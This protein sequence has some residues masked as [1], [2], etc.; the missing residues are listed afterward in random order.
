MKLVIQSQ[1]SIEELTTLVNQIFTKIQN[2][3]NKNEKQ[4]KQDEEEEEI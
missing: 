2:N 4:E 3:D 1:K